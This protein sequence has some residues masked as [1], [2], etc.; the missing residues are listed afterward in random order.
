MGE[1]S[2]VTGEGEWLQGEWLQ[3]SYFEPTLQFECSDVL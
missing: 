1:G 3:D 2:V